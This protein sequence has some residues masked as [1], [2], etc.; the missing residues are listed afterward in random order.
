M[1]RLE[2]QPGRQAGP[3]A[4]GDV[5]YGKFGEGYSRQRRPDPRIEAWIIRA[6]GNA[7][8]V[9]NVGAGAGSYEPLDR[10]VIAVEPSA[11]MRAQRPDHLVPAI[12]GVA[13]DLPLDDQSVDASMALVTAHQWRDLERGLGE[14]RRVTRG[15][16]LVLTF[17]GDA[18]GR[19]WLA[20]Y[21]PAL[22]E[23]ESRRM[24]RIERIMRGLG[25]VAEVIPI[26]IP[27]DCTDG[28]NEAFYAR[29][30]A[31][32]D[33][34]VRR[35]Q[36][37]WSFVPAEEEA[38]FLEILGGDLKSGRWDERHGEWR[39]RPHYDGS[40]RLIVRP[41]SGPAGVL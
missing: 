24:P 11:A 29:P 20:E 3:P 30:E 38:R 33:P 26:P 39:S 25:G 2:Q 8:V 16:I 17:D 31:F 35:A 37:A 22:M 12:H 15:P 41:P 4:A 36:S 32:L 10:H 6:L 27:T 18:M 21:A 28:F 40:L 13:E 14:L 23:R 19:Y 7:R 5:D 34:R 1:S 9:L